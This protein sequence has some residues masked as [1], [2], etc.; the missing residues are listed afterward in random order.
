M[1]PFPSYTRGAERVAPRPSTRRKAA[2]ARRRSH[3]ETQPAPAPR[4]EQ[5]E[6]APATRGIRLSPNAIMAFRGTVRR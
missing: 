4:S 5:V 2:A 1:T 3:A 6:S